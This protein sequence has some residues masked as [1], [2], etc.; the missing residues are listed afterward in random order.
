MPIHINILKRIKLLLG[1]LRLLAKVCY[2]LGIDPCKRYKDL[3]GNVAAG[4]RRPGVITFQQQNKKVPLD[5]I[6]CSGIRFLLALLPRFP[7]YLIKYGV[8]CKLAEP[9]LGLRWLILGLYYNTTTTDVAIS[10]PSSM[11]CIEYTTSLLYYDVYM[12]PMD[13][14]LP[15]PPAGV[16]LCGVRVF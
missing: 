16:C 11:M 1:V 8:V 12:L 10:K 6:T 4:W 15:R 14:I 3:Y 7:G 2:H 9:L 5:F 13:R